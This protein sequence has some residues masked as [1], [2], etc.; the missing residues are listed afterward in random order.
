MTKKSK[1]LPV[2]DVVYTTETPNKVGLSIESYTGDHERVFR[3]RQA[4]MPLYLNNRVALT[5]N[6]IRNSVDCKSVCSLISDREDG[7]ISPYVLDELPQ[8]RHGEFLLFPMGQVVVDGE[9]RNRFAVYVVSTKEADGYITLEDVDKMVGS[10]SFTERNRIS[11]AVNC[12][13]DPTEGKD[14]WNALY[15]ILEGYQTHTSR[16]MMGQ[17]GLVQ[18]NKRER[19]LFEINMEVVL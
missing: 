9:Y 6:E 19:P 10:A 2:R 13:L 14:D 3:M 11:C 7:A 16:P 5:M 12:F 17:I 18:H 4:G 15:F 1:S 8:W